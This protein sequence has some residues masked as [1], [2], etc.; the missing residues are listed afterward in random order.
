M[1]ENIPTAMRVLVRASSPNHNELDLPHREKGQ[2][3]GYNSGLICTV[4]LVQSTV[5][6]VPSAKVVRSWVRAGFRNS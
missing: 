4:L 3:P 2:E 6:V 5:T 1:K